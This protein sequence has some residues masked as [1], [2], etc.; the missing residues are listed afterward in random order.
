M[1]LKYLCLG[2][3]LS[4]SLEIVAASFVPFFNLAQARLQPAPLQQSLSLESAL[5]QMY[6]DN[7]ELW[8]L[9]Q[10]QK[11]WG[12]KALQAG[13]GDNPRLGLN[14]EDFLGSAAFTQDRFS[15]FTLELAQTLPIGGRLERHRHWVKLQQQLAYWDYRVR[16]QD[17]GQR[18]YLKWAHLQ[19]LEA[20]L[21]LAQMIELKAEELHVFLSK[22][23]NMGKLSQQVLLQTELE[24]QAAKAEKAR[25]ELVQMQ[26]KRELALL[27]GGERPAVGPL[28]PLSFE[29]ADLEIKRL[30]VQLNSHPRLARWQIEKAERQAA[31]DFEKAQAVPDLSVTGGL[32]Y[33]P[34][35]DWGTVLLLGWALPINS[36]QGNIQAAQLRQ[37]IW[38]QEQT[39]E[40]NR[41]SQQLDFYAQ[42]LEKQATLLQ[43]SGEQV[44][45]AVEQEQAAQKLFLAG[46]SSYNDVL[47]SY[48]KGLQLRRQLQ[49][50]Q[51]EYFL[52]QVELKTTGP[53]VFAWEQGELSHPAE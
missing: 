41:L 48:Q 1:K 28:E 25:I 6:F 31:L 44:R 45:L 49:Q 51:A 34:P 26:Q 17:L 10:E 53:I 38:Q 13:L 24:I 16:L 37:A 15:Q 23:V 11:M 2:M 52:T 7:P 20:A 19:N 33:H 40:N 12:A 18:V 30:K 29:P 3:L 4:V 46:K 42:Q 32:R 50:V 22:A 43:I 35:V 8:R 9:R 21:V 47:L 39:L 36:N 27:W 14:S 5:K